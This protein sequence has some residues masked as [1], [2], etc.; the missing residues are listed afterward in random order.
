LSNLNRFPKIFALLESVRN[1][2][3]IPDD[4][5]HL[6][7]GMLP[8]YPGKGKLKLQIFCRN[9]QIAF[10]IASTFVIHPQILIFSVFKI[11]NLSPYC[12]G[13]K[14]FHATVLLLIYLGDQFVASEIRHHRRVTAVFFFNNQHDIKR[15]GQDFDTTFVFEGVH[16]EEVD[17]RIS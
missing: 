14:I 11:A 5:A 9:K 12:I 10:L 1:L 2:L 16:S 6:I 15:R 8:H 4:T 13:N 17:R 3:Q 7:L